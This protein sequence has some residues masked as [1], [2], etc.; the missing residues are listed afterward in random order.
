MKKIITSILLVTLFFS[1]S[2]KEENP[3]K[4]KEAEVIQ[5]SANFDWILGK[6]L[7]NNEEEGKETFENWDKISEA[8][9]HGIGFTMQNGDTVKQE[10]IKFIKTNNTW[11]LFV[12]VPE[13]KVPVEFKM[14]E[15]KSDRFTFT[16]DSIDFPKQ[17]EYW[18]DGDKMKALVSGGDLKIPFEFKRIQ[19]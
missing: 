4:P 6:W 19:K 3:S 11:K 16:N 13:D 2:K 18:K 12:K 15:L 9:Y 10:K 17:I 8:E 14:A 5:E 1:C 7:R